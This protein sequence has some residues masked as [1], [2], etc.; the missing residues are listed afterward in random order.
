MC[1]CHYPRHH[2]ASARSLPSCSL[3]SWMRPL[4]AANNLRP[5]RSIKIRHRQD[6][7]Q[8]HYLC[9][10]GEA[11]NSET[12]RSKKFQTLEPIPPPVASSPPPPATSRSY[13]LPKRIELP[14]RSFGRGRSAM[15]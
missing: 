1:S 6:S 5:N 14:W 15:M 7:T 13:H 4:V 8:A 10:K 9:C 2:R 11:A 12:E 3:P